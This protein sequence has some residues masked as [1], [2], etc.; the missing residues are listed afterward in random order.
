MPKPGAHPDPNTLRLQQVIAGLRAGLVVALLWLAP[1]VGSAQLLE[2]A[3]SARSHS[4][5]F[6]VLAQRSVL[7]NPAL[8]NLETNQA[9]L[10]LDPM[11]LPVSCERI[12]ANLWRELGYNGPWQSRIYLAVRPARS[13]D[14]QVNVQAEGYRDGWQYRVVFPEVVQRTRYMRAVVQVLLTEISNRQSRQ[15]PPEIPAW[16][17]EGLCQQLLTSAD[18]PMMLPPPRR[19]ST[20]VSA[21]IYQMEA[22]KPKPLE[23]VHKTLVQTPALTFEELSWPGTTDFDAEDNL[24]YRHSAHFFLHS[25]LKLPNGRGCM[26][27]MLEQLPNYYNWQFALLHGFKDHFQRPLDVE[28]WWSLQVVHFVSRDIDQVWNAEQSARKLE[29]WLHFT[30]QVPTANQSSMVEQTMTVPEV[31][32]N[33]ELEQKVALLQTKANALIQLRIRSAP[34]VIPL[35]DDYHAVLRGFLAQ[36]DRSSGGQNKRQREALKEAQAVALDRLDDIERRLKLAAEPGD[37]ARAAATQALR[38]WK[39]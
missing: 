24:V 18:V 33:W 30:V 14:D 23:Q 3:L 29:E 25:L 10:R 15:R 28:Q 34:E 13:T 27:T 7:G 22:R 26:L 21:H 19:G 31:I 9:I 5:Q 36:V 17:V 38:S 6:L 1:V 37:P 16:L 4:G 11:L 2:D 20:P 32:R 35:V 12:K 8:S 39:P